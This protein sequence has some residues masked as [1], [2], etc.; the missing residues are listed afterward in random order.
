[1]HP[2]SQTVGVPALQ[3]SLRHQDPIDSTMKSFMLSIT[4]KTIGSSPKTASDQAQ[5]DDPLAPPSP[6]ETKSTNPT[7][8][9]QVVEDAWATDTAELLRNRLSLTRDS[10]VG[11]VPYITINREGEEEKHKVHTTRSQVRDNLRYFHHLRLHLRA[12]TAILNRYSSSQFVQFA[13]NAFDSRDPYIAHLATS[14]I[15]FTHHHCAVSETLKSLESNLALNS[16]GLPS[17]CYHVQNARNYFCHS[18]LTP[19]EAMWW[20]S[21]VKKLPD[22]HAHLL[23]QVEATLPLLEGH[24]ADES[25]WGRNLPWQEKED[26][27]ANLEAMTPW[28]AAAASSEHSEPWTGSEMEEDYVSQYE[29]TDDV[30]RW[31]MSHVIDMEEGRVKERDIWFV[32]ESEYEHL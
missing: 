16:F 11:S 2:D 15:L 8:C 30:R 9:N 20:E 25:V 23:K 32:Y 18:L 24:L 27:G 14:Q 31:S 3:I 6:I 12:S 19:G 21:T 13:G 22:I 26:C 4:A 29:K 10:L 28:E 1:M 7:D 5:V 17:N